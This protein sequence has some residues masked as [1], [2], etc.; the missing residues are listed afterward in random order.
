[1]DWS[2]HNVSPET[3]DALHRAA[4]QHAGDGPAS[5]WCISGI[6]PELNGEI[7]Y[8]LREAKVVIESWRRY[9]NAIRPHASLGY[10]PPA[11]EVFMPA[12]DLTGLF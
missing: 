2:K 7:F 10:K 6:P 1:L 5:W 9:Y 11:P 12:F 3:V 8:T 4:A